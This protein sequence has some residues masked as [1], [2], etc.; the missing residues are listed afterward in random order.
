VSFG[1]ITVCG[2][3]LFALHAWLSKAG[4]LSAPYGQWIFAAPALTIGIALG[5]AC[6]EADCMRRRG[7][8]AAAGLAVL[9]G[10][11]LHWLVGERGS[12][13]SYLVAGTALP[14][15]LLLPMPAVALL[16]SFTRVS[17]GVYAMHPLVYLG[18]QSLAGPRF[19]SVWINLPVVFVGA[20]AI[21]SLI[22]K[23][24]W[25]KAVV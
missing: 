23:T 4:T 13:I 24:A 25:G 16:Q 2:I 20:V 9:L 8:V 21:A 17:L 3:A 5:L 10:A 15:T 12:A 6:R 7:L 14:V 18:V 22:R 1:F 11:G 19:N